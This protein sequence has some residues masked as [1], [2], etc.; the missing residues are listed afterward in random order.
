MGRGG[1]GGGGGSGGSWKPVG[2]VAK[3]S[4][5]ST[6]GMGGLD[7]SS[8]L[9]FVTGVVL[10]GG[11]GGEGL[12]GPRAIAPVAWE[13]SAVGGDEREREKKKKK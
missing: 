9:R 12:V 3:S 2:Q 13:S 6:L 10:L 11:M 4:P 5:G 1:D 8:E 7:D